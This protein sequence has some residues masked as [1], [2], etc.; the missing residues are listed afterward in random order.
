MIQ[1]VLAGILSGVG[2]V[3]GSNLGQWT[4][5][6]FA[7]DNPEAAK[8]LTKQVIEPY[9]RGVQTMLTLLGEDIDITGEPDEQT[10]DAVRAFQAKH[11]LELLDGNPGPKTM[12]VIT[13]ELLKRFSNQGGESE[14]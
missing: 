9:F 3:L 6:K 13:S 12:R 8:A 10:E 4:W 2:T 1:I 14:K 7:K 5:D 11:G